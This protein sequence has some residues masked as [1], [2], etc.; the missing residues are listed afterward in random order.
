MAISRLKAKLAKA[1]ASQ[2]VT[3]DDDMTHDLHQIM[4]EE[5][6]NIREKYP[7]GSFK[8]LFWQQ[9]KEAAEK[10]SRGMRWHPLMI[11]WCI[12]L[13]HHSNKAYEALRDSGCVFLPSQRTLRDYTNCVKASAGFSVDVDRQL[14]QAMNLD[15]CEPWQ[16]L[17]VLLL[18]EMHVKENLVF[19]KHSGR[20]IG[21]VDLGD[22][23][24]HLLAF[25]R[26]LKGKEDVRPLAKSMMVFMVRGVFTSHRFVYAQF[27]CENI[28][29]DLLFKPFWDTVYHLERM[30]IKVL[31]LTTY[32]FH[33]DKILTL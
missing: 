14:M 25:E 33:V 1:T 4:A 12:Y 15:N 11:R 24:D 27:P 28:T 30:G 29:G 6:S 19:D 5:E 23:N 18:D 8:A 7:E 3:L 9:Q 21:F 16:K 17:V 13:R 22:V 2:G 26:A 10:S 31:S 32:I 20:L